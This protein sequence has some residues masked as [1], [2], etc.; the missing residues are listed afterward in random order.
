MSTE[1]LSALAVRICVVMVAHAALGLYG[2]YLLRG[3]TGSTRRSLYLAGF[4]AAVALPWL[5]PVDPP[6]FRFVVALWSFL[7]AVRLADVAWDRYPAPEPAGSLRWFLLTWISGPDVRW[8]V[9]DA[10]RTSARAAG[11]HRLGRGAL[12]I[13]G[14][15]GMFALSTAYPAIHD[16][17][18]TQGA[19]V[20][21][22]SLFLMPGALAVVTGFAMFAAGVWIEESFDCPLLARSP[23]DFW[24]RR[25][26]RLFQ[27]SAQRHIFRPLM[28]QSSIPRRQRPLAALLAVFV[29][30][31][32]LHEY[33]IV[34]AVGRHIGYMTAFFALHG[35]ATW[36]DWR[37]RSRP[38]L[39]APLAIVLHTTW[40]W[41]GFPLFMIPVLQAI[42]IVEVRLW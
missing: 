5:A 33:I 39:P 23:R 11:R 16:G 13:A 25:W 32:A 41:A 31:A 1:E 18:W 28:R 12:Q 29:F 6:L 35:V 7:A 36:A 4:A 15:M 34:A 8:P 20:L 21:A 24:S 3:R 40:F 14:A 30:S 37:W 27:A 26:N 19:W 10:D 22:V 42:P 38:A 17:L 9:D 2:H